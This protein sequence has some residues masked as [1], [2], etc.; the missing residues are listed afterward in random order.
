MAGREFDEAL[1][2]PKMD[3]AEIFTEFYRKNPEALQA[4]ALHR[5]KGG[6][7]GQQLQLL[8]HETQVLRGQGFFDLPPPLL[9]NHPHLYG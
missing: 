7:I 3:E 2:R 1:V 5:V 4:A 9:G 6:L 8:T